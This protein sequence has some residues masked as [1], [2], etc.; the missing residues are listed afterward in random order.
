MVGGQRVHVTCPNP[1][2]SPKVNP[3]PPPHIRTH[4]IGRHLSPLVVVRAVH[5]H[6]ADVAHRHRA[7]RG[8]ELLDHAV[9]LQLQVVSSGSEHDGGIHITV[10][11]GFLGLFKGVCAEGERGGMLTCVVLLIEAAM[12]CVKGT[13]SLRLAKGTVA[14]ERCLRCMRRVW[15]WTSE[16][17]VHVNEVLS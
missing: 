17:E 3:P 2:L 15:V 7:V 6:P 5:E 14:R 1:C 9:M 16:S 11:T 10:L 4:H 8:C 12:R 13:W